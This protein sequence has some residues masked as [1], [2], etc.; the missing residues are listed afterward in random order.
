[1]ENFGPLRSSIAEHHLRFLADVPTIVHCH[2]FNL[3]LDQTIDDALGAEVGLRVRT[4]AAQESAHV[5]LSAVNEALGVRAVDE[6][7]RVAS[8]VFRSM[9]QGT[10]EFDVR[11]EGGE[12]TGAFLH[13]GFS[14]REK[15]GRDIKR[16]RPADGF[17][18][19]FAAAATEVA[20]GLPLW[21]LEARERGC[22]SMRSE[23]CRFDISLRVGNKPAPEKPV[24][25]EATRS[26]LPA[27]VDGF[28]D[29]E[30][31]ATTQ[32]LLD[33][34]EGVEA[35]ARGLVQAFG[36]FITRHLAGY[37]NRVSY[38][39]VELLRESNAPLVPILESLFRESGQVCAFHTFGGILLSPEWEAL[40][41][42]P[43]GDVE[44]HV[45]RCAAIARALGFGRWTVH[46]LEPDARLVL[47]TPVTYETPY[48]LVRH[49]RQASPSSY[50]LQGA[51]LAFMELAHRLDW[52]G[53]PQLD[54]ALYR[55]LFSAGAHWKVEQTAD[56]ACGDAF[57]EVVVTRR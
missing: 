42:A 21:T 9:G 46:E 37:H 49:G 52:Q 39:A 41:G 1:M 17:A 34:L 22:V 20:H 26:V 45:I 47:R 51:S 4:D 8:S 27:V 7:L 2:H 3:F 15:Y 5:L 44:R 29:A 36:V 11:P 28:A 38:A 14:W 57:C 55:R 16:R 25:V 50:F 56:T 40:V 33:F 53:A 10:L 31:E 23:R 6:C 48:C 18:A 19:G 12:A 32:Q 43:D 35:D 13:Y 54:D 24:D 30:I